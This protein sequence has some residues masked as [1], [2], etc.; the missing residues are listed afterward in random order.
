MGANRLQELVGEFKAVFAG[1]GVLV[2]TV[3]PPAVFLV[4]EAIWDLQLASYVALGVGLAL[5]LV[6]LAKGQPLKY[7]LGGL[8]GAALASLAARAAGR[9]EGYFLP[10]LVS[11]G[12]SF[13]V[14]VASI[15]AR[16]PMVAWTSF[17][18]R[19]WPLA[20]YWHPR[21]RPAYSEVTWFWAIFFAARLAVQILTLERGEVGL[22]YAVQLALGWPA[23][24][25]LL[26]AS[27]IYGT[28]RLKRLHG[29]SV[30]EF[31]SGSLPPWEGQQRGF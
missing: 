9:L 17:F 5:G 14:A 11:G 8:G 16:R 30:Q 19:R 26:A 24:V 1:R 13:A 12:V 28:W 2:D 20:W 3:A 6:R 22:I 25:V 23:T 29:P 15:L 7:A 4:S 27:Y 18:A 31:K 10:S 21:I